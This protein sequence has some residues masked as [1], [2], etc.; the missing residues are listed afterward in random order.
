MTTI[1]KYTLTLLFVLF[2][3]CTSD[4]D[5]AQSHLDNARKYYKQKEFALAA[6]E[7]DS[8]KVLYPKAIEQ[9]KAGLALLDSVRRGENVYI[10]SSCDSLI[11]SLLPIVEQA[12]KSFIYRHNK[13]YQDAG[14]YISREAASGYTGSAL[15]RSGVTEDGQLY[16]ESVFIGA[17][18]H[19]K[20]KISLKDGS[21]AET[22]S[23]TD[24]GLN[25]RFSNMEK[26]YEIIRFAGP[27]ENG[28]GKFIFSNPD[29]ILT[30]TI[31]G[32]GKYSYTLPQ[33]SQ[34]AIG[35]SYELSVMMSQLDSLRTAREKAGF[36]LYNMDYKS[37]EAN[38]DQE[39]L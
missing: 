10:I 3:A 25:Y 32:N 12:K 39:P 26:Q 2:F 24:D 29:K 16:L 20:L 37:P 22:S 31:E 35:K 5:D 28:V 17:Q 21:S 8:I 23:V 1:C 11:E 18:R 15:L 33:V 14:N 19:N 4:K 6:Q 36:R 30:V 7:I 38:I 27:A 9:R 13:E 34:S